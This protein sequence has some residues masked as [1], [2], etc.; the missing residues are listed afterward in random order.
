M[1]TRIDDP[2]WTQ[3][4]LHP[5]YCPTQLYTQW[6]NNGIFAAIIETTLNLLYQTP[7]FPDNPSRIELCLNKIDCVLEYENIGHTAALFLKVAQ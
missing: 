2:L 1:Y 3:Q 5:L 7:N 4:H 6:K